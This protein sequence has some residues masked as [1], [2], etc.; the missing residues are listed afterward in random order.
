[1][2]ELLLLQDRYP[3]VYRG[4]GF[5]RGARFCRSAP[6][7]RVV[8]GDRFGNLGFRPV[9][10]VI[11]GTDI[12]RGIH[13]GS[14]G[15][16]A[17]GCRAAYRDVWH[18]V[19]RDDDLGFRP[20]AETKEVLVNEL[21]LLQDS[22]PRVY[23]GGSF[24]LVARNCRSAYRLW[25]E[26]GDRSRNRGF[27][28][29][30]EVKEIP[31]KEKGRVFRGVGWFGGAFCARCAWRGRL[32]PW[33]RDPDLGFRPV[34]EVAEVKTGS[35]PRVLRGGSWVYGARGAHCVLRR[36]NDPGCRVVPYGF[37]PVAETKETRMSE[38]P[39]TEQ[40]LCATEHL[41]RSVEFYADY[42]IDANPRPLVAPSYEDLMR[43]IQDLGRKALHLC[44]EIQRLK[45]IRPEKLTFSFIIEEDGTLSFHAPTGGH[46][47]FVDKR[48][49]SS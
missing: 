46:V 14:F 7:G 35:G 17:R 16:T 11:A 5:W 21:P 15:L 42:Y 31:G 8:P 4:G 32:R 26:P 43:T 39:L 19:V 1:M 24:W 28:P 9:A 18:P 40:E 22:C 49:K 13:G 27:R 20:V 45:Q 12:L 30:A 25:F 33:G 3:R 34:A 41:A 2:S 38:L 47:T 36:A 37:R 48:Q 23:R 29:V 10:E 44:A 6:R